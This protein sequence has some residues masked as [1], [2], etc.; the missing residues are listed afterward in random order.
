MEDQTGATTAVTTGSE[1]FATVYRSFFSDNMN[2]NVSVATVNV[3]DKV[4]MI[5]GDT[6]DLVMEARRRIEEAEPIE[7]VEAGA[8]EAALPE[9]V[10][11][12]EDVVAGEMESSAL[13]TEMPALDCSEGGDYEDTG[14]EVLETVSEAQDLLGSPLDTA[15]DTGVEECSVEE[16]CS[17]TGGQSVGHKCSVCLKTFKHKG[18]T[19]ISR[20]IS[21]ASS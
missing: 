19:S 5:T 1:D 9:D 17:S 15:A 8:V 10:F 4:L 14:A 18:T 13:V 11:S 16:P 12:G 7:P 3:G 2:N 21:M 20:L 6:M